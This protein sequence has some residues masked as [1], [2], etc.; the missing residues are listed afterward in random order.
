MTR[1]SVPPPVAA[2]TTRQVA[3]LISEVAS[4]DADPTVVYV[5]HHLAQGE[6]CLGLWPLPPG[7][8]H[9]L[10]PLVGFRAPGSWEA[11]GVT[12]T[13]T[14]RHLDQPD[15]A[16]AVRAT[17][18]VDRTGGVTSTLIAEG[19]PLD[20]GDEPPIG[21]VVDILARALD[22]P[23][24]PPEWSTAMLVE[25]TW[26]D[27]MASGLLQR[28]ARG[29]SWR[30][31]ADRHPL[32]GGGPVPEPEELARRTVRHAKVQ[33]WAD[34]RLAA[35]GAELPAATCGPPGG[36]VLDAYDWFDDGSL[37]RWSLQGL[38]PAEAVLADL[39]G[40]LP[41]HVGAD[42]SRALTQVRGM[43]AC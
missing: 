4:P 38:P 32:R 24:P 10:A 41:G 22:L 15:D 23:T 40:I 3:E 36:Q 30:W 29:R 42:L 9:P 11:L 18:L 12:C 35:T 5:E 7:P 20:V 16:S 33:S 27:R 26:L 19:E 21:L 14:A 6:L 39:L 25:S 43:T 34:L 8:G 2:P 31:V 37:C 17:V 1:A 13:A 28:P